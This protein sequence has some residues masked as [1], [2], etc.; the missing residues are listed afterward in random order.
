MADVFITIVWIFGNSKERSQKFIHYGLGQAKLQ[1]EHRK[2]DLQRREPLEGEN[3]DLD[4]AEEWINQQRLMFLTEVNLGSWSGVTTR[5]MAEK[6]GCLDFYNYVYMPFSACV[7]SM[8]HHVAKYNLK[9]CQNVLHRFHSIP[10]VPTLPV[11]L[12]YFYL[13]AKYLQKT[14][15]R[16][17][18]ETGVSVY[19]PSAFDLVCEGIDA[20]S[21]EGE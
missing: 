4:A 18:E 19:V 14:F 2:A 13:A 12:N 7:H 6:G 9:Q 17:D 10:D 5:K 16:F 20:L 11:D 8:W 3:D 1:L 15:A 21:V